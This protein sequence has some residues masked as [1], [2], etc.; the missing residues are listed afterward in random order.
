MQAERVFW[1]AGIWFVLLWLNRHRGLFFG[2]PDSSDVRGCVGDQS[3]AA[4]VHLVRLPSQCVSASLGF[5]DSRHSLDP[6]ESCMD[7]AAAPD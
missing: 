6:V 2:I 7:G 5:A 1:L 3:P 4:T